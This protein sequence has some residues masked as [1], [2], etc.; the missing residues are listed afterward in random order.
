[1]VVVARCCWGCGD[2][3]SGSAL[4]GLDIGNDSDWRDRLS[5][6][7]VQSP[8]LLDYPAIIKR[9]SWLSVA[10]ERAV[11]Q[12]N[13]SRSTSAAGNRPREMRRA[14]K[15]EIEKT[16]TVLYQIRYSSRKPSQGCYFNQPET[17]DLAW[18]S[19]FPPRLPCVFA[20]FAV[21]ASQQRAKV[22]PSSSKQQLLPVGGNVMEE[23]WRRGT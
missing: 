23:G 12:G 15:G 20:L 2:R 1:M 9:C 8:V 3:C 7:K 14:N 22:L 21:R 11:H 6:S 5:R 13:L 19:H 4:T 17:R 18:A 10:V 16:V